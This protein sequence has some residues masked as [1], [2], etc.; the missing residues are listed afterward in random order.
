MSE[1]YPK[2]IP[3]LITEDIFTALCQVKKVAMFNCDLIVE[4]LNKDTHEFNNPAHLKAIVDPGDPE[5]QSETSAGLDTWI[6]PYKISVYL[7]PSQLDDMPI[8]EA[9]DQVIADVIRALCADDE[10]SIS[11]RGYTRGGLAED[12]WA[13]GVFTEDRVAGTLA[14]LIHVMIHVRY[15]TRERD[16]Y[17]KD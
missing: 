3:T 13:D 11:P 7:I 6:R 17:L 15:T 5:K 4:R 12:T 1:R 14:W 10:G 9:T 8:D 16:L 2:P